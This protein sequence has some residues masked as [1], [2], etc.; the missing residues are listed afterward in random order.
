[1]FEDSSIVSS[2]ASAFN[3]AALVGPAFFWRAVLCI[4]LF[5][6][7]YMA[8]RYFARKIDIKSYLAPNIT[9][10]WVV[11]LTM[12]WLVFFGGN[13]QVLRDE[14]SLLPWVSAAILFL[15][16]LFIGTKTQKLKMP[17][18]YGK[19]DATPR[20]RWTINILIILLLALIIGGT[21]LRQWW[22]PLVQIGALVFGLLLGRVMRRSVN[23]IP[24]SGCI[25]LLAMV[26]LL[27]QPEYFRFGQL[28]NLTLIHLLWILAT[29]MVTICALVMNTVNC[30]GRIHESAY[31]KIKWLMRFLLV[32]CAV[33]FVLTESVPMFIATV[34]MMAVLS[35][36]SMWHLTDM[37]KD[38]KDFMIAF[39]FVFFGILIGVQTITALGILMLAVLP[40]SAKHSDIKHL[41]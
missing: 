22:T 7:I 34:A 39:S 27:M 2:A 37:S 31:K 23:A 1:M 24:Y 11:V 25:M 17:V 13:Y 4:P 32:L 9:S 41:L 26:A 14:I 35:A 16:A 10:F 29:G 21:D 40:K 36:T 28:G 18:W 38:N 3:N 5:T 30:R 20:R 6:G 33:L 19:T 8:G 12:L 15:S